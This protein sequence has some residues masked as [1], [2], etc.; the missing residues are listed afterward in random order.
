MEIVSRVSKGSK[1][2]QVYLPKNRPGLAVGNYVVIKLLQ[3]ADT[4]TAL[5][6]SKKPC[7]YG[8]KNIE[9]IKVEIIQKVSGIIEENAVNCDNI[10]IT[11][12]F[13]ERGFNFND[14]DILIITDKNINKKMIESL[15]EQKT[16]IKAHIIILSNN[17][18]VNGLK[19][20]PLYHL[21]LSRCVAKKRFIHKT[22]KAI[23]YKILDLHLLKSK[24]LIDNFDVLDGSEKYKFTRNIIAISSFIAGK[25]VTN[26]SVNKEI[27]R[28]FGVNTHNIKYNI[29]NKKSFL[30]NY[31]L[32]Y[33]K[34]FNKILK[35]I[36]T[37]N[38][39]KQKKAY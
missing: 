28:I 13:L 5:N 3:E 18:I 14:V 30:K 26:E 2:D 22:K 7:F 10:I 24:T 21:M 35:G 27:K 11:G 20:D 31:I 8:V 38:C 32:I 37:K 9:P 29:I 6:A 23:N 15:V 17:E 39:S 12:S 36:S 34:T 33:N 1:M 25:K 4:A 16:G 19:T